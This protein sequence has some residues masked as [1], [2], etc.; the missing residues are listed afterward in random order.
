MPDAPDLP[1]PPRSPHPA[2][3][4]A[5]LLLLLVPLLLV[6]PVLLAGKL[7]LPQVPAA[8]APFREEDPE[9]ARAAREEQNYPQSDRLFPVLTDQ[10]AMRAALLAGEAPLWE[11]LL[12]LGAP[13]FAE[14]IAGVAYPPNWLAF[15][16]PPEEAAGPLALVSLFLAGLGAWLF[17]GRVGLSTGARL[18]GALAFQL[19]GWGVGNLFYYMKLDAGLWFPW[20]L[21]A[22][23]GIARGRRRSG[24]WLSLSLAFSVLAG[25]L[26]IGVFVCAGTGLY[27]LLRLTR[28]WDPCCARERDEER[29][30]TSFPPLATAALFCLLGLG[31]ASVL[32]VPALEASRQ[33]ERQAASLAVLQSESL[34][35]A[36][37]LGTIVHD[38]FGSATEDT[39]PGH[40]PVAG[41]LTPADEGASAEVA[42][43]NEWNLY[44]GLVVVV[45]AVVGLVAAPRRALAPALMLL[46]V[47]GFAQGW[48]GVRLLYR[49]PGLDAGHPARVLALAWFLWPWLGAV[50][51]E[52]LLARR[53]RAVQAF[54][55]LAALATLAGL[56]LWIRLDPVAWAHHLDEL[57]L[58]R[59][60]AFSTVD[61]LRRELFSFEAAVAAGERLRASYRL[62]FATGL[63]LL[64]AAVLQ[65]I[66]SARGR[67]RW[68]PLVAVLLI[69][70]LV[71]SDGHATGRPRADGVFP[72]SS[73]IDAIRTAA[74]DG[75]VLRYD[76]S[77][78]GVD[79]VV[80]LARPNMLEPYG[81]GDLAP[82][83]VFPP[84]TFNELFAAVDP[85]SRRDQ[86]VSRI[87][88]LAL[89]D[90][91]VLDLLRATCVL[92]REAIEHPR[93]EP[94]LERPGFHVYRRSGC[95]GPARVVPAALVAAS[96][97]AALGALAGRLIDFERQTLLA[98]GS[99]PRSEARDAGA[100][101][102][103]ERVRRGRI[104]V[105]VEDSTG[106]W[107]VLH[108]QFYPGW[109]ATRNGEP[110]QVLR[111][112]HVY[113]AVELVPGRNE[114]VLSYAPGSVRTGLLLTGLS[115]L[116]ALILSRRLGV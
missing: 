68:V 5:P 99:A 13:L 95:F 23:E 109:S 92:S 56:L 105:V 1:R 75:R 66:A 64:V 83:I 87:S 106:G 52:A 14:S 60:G 49:V 51:V 53:P 111:A 94:V 74:G 67:L 69:E 43:Q 7:F 44:A 108:E 31:G 39:P 32:L 73:G 98:P 6:G 29:R 113:Q 22:V 77:E 10:T 72:A 18:F 65:R 89:L 93:L 86:G 104:E 59:Y 30:G 11:P 24:L 96:D 45:L 26:A 2:E 91:P 16:L 103:Y 28:P 82:W 112:D 79:D 37:L 9:R 15:L 48:H 84:R 107:L 54:A 100:L 63:L 19:G 47:I 101:R 20:A 33:S 76:P 57:L 50:G 71:A 85:R 70:G 97:E 61:D 42:N 27:A 12:G 38:L 62:L 21:W 4:R 40:L 55:V 78:S 116:L 80:D 34:P 25:M 81:I 58:Q 102:L 36:T 88:D 3:R 46:F 8:L 90:H 17:L 110:A 114:V 115:L 35:V 41:W